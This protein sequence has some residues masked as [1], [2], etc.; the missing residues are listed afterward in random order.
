MCGIMRAHRP[1]WN[2]H[3]RDIMAA[4]R[5]IEPG[6]IKAQAEYTRRIEHVRALGEK[7]RAMQRLAA[8]AKRGA[9]SKSPDQLA[10]AAPKRAPIAPTPT[11]FPRTDGGWT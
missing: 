10:P 4:F 9:R 8:T 7:G 1:T 6:L 2:T 3:K 11:P 5:E